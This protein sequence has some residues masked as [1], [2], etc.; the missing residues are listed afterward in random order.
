M[1]HEPLTQAC[2]MYI[3]TGDYVSQERGLAKG[4][5]VTGDHATSSYI[6]TRLSFSQQCHDVLPAAPINLYSNFVA[7]HTL[8]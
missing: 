3:S 1:V 2:A 8:S 4:T 7:H 5:T 6:C